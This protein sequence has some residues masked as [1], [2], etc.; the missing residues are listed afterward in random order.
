M[1]R[2]VPSPNLHS[3]TAPSNQQPNSLTG[4]PLGVQAEQPRE[5]L[6]IG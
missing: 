5:D 4:V 1:M 6:V 3:F 2:P